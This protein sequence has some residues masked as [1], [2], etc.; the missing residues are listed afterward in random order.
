MEMAG[1]LQEAIRD[2]SDPGV[3]MRRVVD[4]ALVLIAAADGA[5][6]ELAADGYLTYVCAAGSLA[7]HVGTRLRASESLSGLAVSCG[8]TLYCEDAAADGRVDREACL[9]VGAVSMVCVPLR[10]GAEVIGVLKVTSGRAC[11]F[12]QAQVEVLAALAGFIST[13]VGAVSDISQSAS[14]LL[15]RR[16]AAPVSVAATRTAGGQADASAG[17][18]LIGTF[19]ANVLRPGVATG[20]AARQ[21]VEAVLAGGSLKLVGQPIVDLSDGKLVGVEA[22]A[23]FPGQ[24]QQPPDVWFSQAHDAGLGVALEL[25]AFQLAL[26]LLEQIPSGAYLAI[27]LSPHSLAAGEL[28]RLL[29][30]GSC[31]RIVIELTEHM[32]IDDYPRCREHVRRI[33]EHGAR[34]AI[35]DTG[36][37][38]ASLSHIVNLAPDLIKLDRQFTTGIDLDPVRR[39]LA[40]ALVSFAQDTG[41][42]V[43]AEGIETTDELDTVRELGIPY[44][45][46]YLIGRPAPPAA[47]RK[48]YSQIAQALTTRLS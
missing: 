5:V 44:G 23:R 36:A 19:V 41:A 34:L 30:Q 42:Q 43:I 4:Q 24:P 18:E 22:L 16:S 28:P 38:F 35:D 31:E 20:L 25:E 7:G 2:A 37:G 12:T 26:A 45:Q 48:R 17:G 9:R 27:N 11:A 39:A 47:I 1:Q 8:E 14:S 21:R 46:G 3:V 33:R 32:R 13:A 29:G 40:Q 6:V 15:A 10:R